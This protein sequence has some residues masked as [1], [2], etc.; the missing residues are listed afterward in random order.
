[1]LHSAFV[2]TK[3]NSSNSANKIKLCLLRISEWLHLHVDALVCLLSN[4]VPPHTAVKP[5]VAVRVQVTR[6]KTAGIFC[7]LKRLR[8]ARLFAP[9]SLRYIPQC[10]A[11]T[12][13]LSRSGHANFG[14]ALRILQACHLRDG[15]PCAW[16]SAR[17]DGY[18]L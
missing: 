6:T 3:P 8:T 10:E 2:H 15:T 7:K 13:K 11:N 12:C 17:R 9:R 18:W 14:T 5:R 1:M 16:G 4:R